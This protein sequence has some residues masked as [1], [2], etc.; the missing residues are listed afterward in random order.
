[1]VSAGRATGGPWP[2][3]ILDVQIKFIRKKNNEHSRIKMNFRLKLSH[4]IGT[5]KSA[6]GA[7]VAAR[8]FRALRNCD[9]AAIATLVHMC[10]KKGASGANL[11]QKHL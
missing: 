4:I 2:Y 11:A 1:M 5:C 6:R 3:A 9:L 7:T 10:T 8:H